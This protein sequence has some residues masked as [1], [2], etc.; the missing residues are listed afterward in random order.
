MGARCGRESRSGCARRNGASAGRRAVRVAPTVVSTNSYS[1]SSSSTTRLNN[2]R[3][4]ST[5]RIPDLAA[6]LSRRME[7]DC[8]PGSDLAVAVSGRA[9]LPGAMWRLAGPLTDDSRRHCDLTEPNGFH[10]DSTQ[11]NANVDVARAVALGRRD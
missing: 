2:Y 5:L 3:S 6:Y 8:P 10:L 7:L 9:P 11:E 1:S 4:V